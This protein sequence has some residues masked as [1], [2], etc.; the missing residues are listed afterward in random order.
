MYQDAT[1]EQHKAEVMGRLDTA[2]AESLGET[3]PEPSVSATPS[4]ADD[5][6]AELVSVLAAMPLDSRLAVLRGMN[7]GRRSQVVAMLPQAA[8]IETLT[9]LLS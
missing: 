8:Q 9:A 2:L 3:D 6:T 5:D 4:P 1:S 7:V